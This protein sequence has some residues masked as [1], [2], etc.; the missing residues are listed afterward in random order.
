[1]SELHGPQSISDKRLMADSA[2][3]NG[4]GGIAIIND[5][6]LIWGNYKSSDVPLRW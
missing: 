5:C 1:M 4:D 2:E 6:R 3:K